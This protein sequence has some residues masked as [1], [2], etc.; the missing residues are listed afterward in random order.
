M[1]TKSTYGTLFLLLTTSLFLYI[2]YGEILS[3]S[4]DKVIQQSGDAFNAYNIVTYHAKYDES[5]SVFK[6]MGYPY[7]E[8]VTIGSTIPLISNSLRFLKSLGIDLTHRTTQV[9]HYSMILSHLLCAVFIYLIFIRLKVS[10]VISTVLAIAITFMAPQTERL[11]CHFGLAHMYV[12]PATIFFLMRF[13]A[14]DDKRWSSIG[15]FLT[16]V[17]ASLIQFYFFAITTFMI[18][19]FYFVSILELAR[20]RRNKLNKWIFP[21]AKTLNYLLHFGFQSILPFLI[22]SWWIG[23]FEVPDRPDKPW[24]YFVFISY[25]EGVFTSIRMPYFRWINDHLI[26][27]RKVSFESVAYVGLVSSGVFVFMVYYWIRSKC[28]SSLFSWLLLVYPINEVEETTSLS[29]SSLS[30]RSASHDVEVLK[31]L[32]Y[33]SILLLAFSFGL[34]FV[35]PGLEGWLDYAGPLKQFRAV[36]RFNWVFYFVMNIVAFTLLYHVLRHKMKWLVLVLLILGYESYQFNQTRPYEL[37]SINEL[38]EGS[39]LSDK[40][41]FELGNYQAILPI[42]YYHVGTDNF[43]ERVHGHIQQKSSLLSMETGLPLIAALTNRSSLAWAYELFRL[44]SEPYDN[45]EVLNEFYNDKA[46]LLMI[47]SNHFS[48][49]PDL[50]IGTKFLGEVDGM[51]YYELPLEAFQKRIAEKKNAIRTTLMDAVLFDIDGYRSTDS[52]KTF[53]YNSFDE[54]SSKGYRGA[55]VQL[56]V[57]EPQNIFTEVISSSDGIINE[58]SILSLWI[59]D[60]RTYPIGTTFLYIKLYDAK[61]GGLLW[62]EFPQIRYGLSVMAKEGWSLLEIPIVIPQE[63]RLEIS[64]HNASLGDKVINVDELLIRRANTDLYRP[65]ELS[66]NNRFYMD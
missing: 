56:K 15:L 49:F 10:H 45:L 53:V 60:L 4:S 41:Q 65:G 44:S 34:P 46:I 36:G 16:V 5:Y 55:G 25:W 1:N 2:R 20:P 50:N 18:G 6:G 17:S 39:K 12:I 42:P 38:Q 13:D 3:A 11:F 51:R 62:Q 48:E 7:G 58:P 28:K 47:D 31:R 59:S 40:I 32:F 9:L 26:E 35:I 33:M 64:V 30:D 14:D 43:N 54:Q 24:G 57:T 22:F 37:H 19:S 8:H 29:S 66:K 27:I 52:I 23:G 63:G 61:T 21:K